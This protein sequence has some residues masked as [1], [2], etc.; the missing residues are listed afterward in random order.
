MDFIKYILIVKHKFSGKVFAFFYFNYGR[1]NFEQKHLKITKFDKI[2]IVF[3]IS[4]LLSSFFIIIDLKF[5]L[6]LKLWMSKNFDSGNFENFISL[7][8]GLTLV[9]FVI[10]KVI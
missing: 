7:K 10:R 6:G 2:I 3:A 5:S 4:F 9:I 8:V 1:N